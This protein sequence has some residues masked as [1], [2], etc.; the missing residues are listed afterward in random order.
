VEA[1]GIADALEHNSLRIVEEPLTGDPTEGRAG[2]H[3]RT[4][5]RMHRQVEDEFAPQRARVREHDD[6]EPEGALAARDLDL[7]D[8]R[9]IDLG[10]LTNEGLGAQ[11]GL[12]RRSRP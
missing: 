1:H 6:E 10:L 4:A 7:A 3:K 12:A 9:P 2:T 11:V 5:K 8:V